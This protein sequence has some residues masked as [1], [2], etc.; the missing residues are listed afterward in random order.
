ME[1]YKEII[2]ENS[3][4]E[5]HEFEEMNKN[6]RNQDENLKG[7]TQETHAP[8]AKMC[9]KCDYIAETDKNLKDHTQKEHAPVNKKCK[10][11][12]YTNKTDGNLKVHVQNTHAPIEVDPTQENAEQENSSEYRC[13]FCEYV[14]G[15][16]ETIWNHKLD[17]HTGQSFNFNNLDKDG[18]KDS[19]LHLLAGQNI[20]LL[21]EVMSMKK[22]L[23]E[24][25]GQMID[26]CE[27]SM[28]ELKNEIRKNTK[29]TTAA[30]LK[31]QQRIGK[32]NR[33]TKILKSN[34]KRPMESKKEEKREDVAKKA[35]KKV[36]D[37]S[38]SRSDSKQSVPDT[39]SSQSPPS[40]HT[41][42]QTPPPP[43]RPSHFKKKK[44]TYL[45]KPKVLVI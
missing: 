26:D 13:N 28:T 45:K 32:V 42:W 27:E 12:V 10:Q 38:E 9:N 5:A 1:H 20:D 2:N 31:L 8:V 3:E 36:G 6:S 14:S 41:A 29:E 16:I 44:S 19:V 25:V 7:H 22:A 34:K 43:K 11:C 39:T 17:K 40:P 24:V 30:L 18:S 37:N 23:K 4:F 15:S 21:E 35:K 33:S